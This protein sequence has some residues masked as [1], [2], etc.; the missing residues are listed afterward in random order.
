ML[1]F[2]MFCLQQLLSFSHGSAYPYCRWSGSIILYRF[3]VLFKVMRCAFFI[4]DNEVCFVYFRQWGVHYLF[5][6]R[7]CA[8]FLSD[9]EICFVSFRQWGV[10][11][12]AVLHRPGRLEILSPRNPEEGGVWI[13]EK[14]GQGQHCY[15]HRERIV[16]VGDLESQQRMPWLLT[17]A[18]HHPHTHKSCSWL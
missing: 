5:P 14:E 12:L 3:W 8:L 13:P 16:S 17:H 4:S 2:T 18:W 11:C 6:T 1:L 7:R 15:R 10:L 9:N